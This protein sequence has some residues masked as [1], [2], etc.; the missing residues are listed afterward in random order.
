MIEMLKVCRPRASHL[1]RATLLARAPMSSRHEL[2][3]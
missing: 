1:R 2:T 3:A